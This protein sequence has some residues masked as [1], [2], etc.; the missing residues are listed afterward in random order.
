MELTK[1]TTILLPPRLH[2]Q[3][4]LLAR[5]RQVSVGHL[6]RFACQRQYGLA[7]KED[8]LKAVGELCRLELPV[9]TVARMKKESVFDRDSLPP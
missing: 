7:S 3:L 2:K 8:R 1:K 9:A 5:E 6:I 4:T